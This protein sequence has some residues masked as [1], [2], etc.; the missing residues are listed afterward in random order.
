MIKKIILALMITAVSFG[1][2][3]T[4]AQEYNTEIYCHGGCYGDCHDYYNNGTS[5]GD[6]NIYG[7]HG[8]CWR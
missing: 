6:G 5:E 8:G 3:P 1:C 2:T 7:R 4:E